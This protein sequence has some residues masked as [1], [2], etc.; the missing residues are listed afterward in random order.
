[1]SETQGDPALSANNPVAPSVP[2]MPPDY[3]LAGP[4][5]KPIPVG[6]PVYDTNV[7]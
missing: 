5:D 4:D 2:P 6:I 3:P 1:M 7:D